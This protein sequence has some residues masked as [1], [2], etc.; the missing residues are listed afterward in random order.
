MN[1]I[2]DMKEKIKLKIENFAQILSAEIDFGDLTILT[3]YQ[4]SGKS[5]VC[6]LVKL[7]NDT[8]YVIDTL[9]KNGYNW[10]KNKE[11][12]DE[13]LNLYFGQPSNGIWKK[14]TKIIYNLKE[15]KRIDGSKNKSAPSESV[16]YVP[17]QRV[18]TLAGGWPR[19][20]REYDLDTPFVVSNFSE[21]ARQLLTNKFSEYTK[22]FPQ[23]GR[24]KPSTRKLISGT[25]YGGATVKVDTWGNRKRIVLDVDNNLIGFPAWSAGQREFL[26]LLLGL[27]EVMPHKAKSKA[28]EIKMIILEEPEMGLH[29]KATLLFVLLAFELIER[30]YKVVIS[31]HSQT[32][33]EAAW[34]L[35][36]LK[37]DSDYKKK[38]LGY[39]F[40]IRPFEAG[41]IFKSYISDKTEIKVYFFD[42]VIDTTTVKDISDLD[43]S[44]DDLIMNSWGGMLSFNDRA[45]HA[46]AESNAKDIFNNLESND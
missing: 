2:Y 32:V 7:I 9:E 16:Y 24:M 28:E 34:A 21:H 11:S 22:I 45:T 3:G 42:R 35:R 26:P 37:G 4:A 14:E 40:D 20:F 12:N 1:Y 23:E 27:Y 31:T 17:A 30:G 13:F 33:V 41:E 8:R 29:P 10:K 18:N 25:I 19:N 46:V 38:K 6:Q 44:S 15:V 5:L 43:T 39:I 36:K